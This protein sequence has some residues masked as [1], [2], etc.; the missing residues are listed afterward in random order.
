MILLEDLEEG[1]CEEGDR[2]IAKTHM[3]AI[4]IT[5]ITHG[6]RDND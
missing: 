6:I 5:I 3:L 2:T 4:M 1:V